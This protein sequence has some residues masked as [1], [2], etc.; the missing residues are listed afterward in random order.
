MVEMKAAMMVDWMAGMMAA[1]WAHQKVGS[2][3]EMM[4]AQMDGTKVGLTANSSAE[5]MV[6]TKAD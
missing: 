4:V 1:S 3:V 2:L 6:E 5:K